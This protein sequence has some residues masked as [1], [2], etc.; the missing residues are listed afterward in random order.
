MSTTLDRPVPTSVTSPVPVEL[1]R[2]RVLHR[3]LNDILG[4]LGLSDA[5]GE[6]WA[7]PARSGFFFAPHNLHQA[8]RLVLGLERLGALLDDAGI[9]V[10]G[11]A[12]DGVADGQLAFPLGDGS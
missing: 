7:T 2:A 9:E 1:A 5:L 11:H 4:D 8:Q 6:R 3:R 10:P 12:T